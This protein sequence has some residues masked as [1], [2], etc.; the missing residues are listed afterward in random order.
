MQRLRDLIASLPNLEVLVLEA[1]PDHTPP[2]TDED[3]NRLVA[4]ISSRS[5]WDAHLKWQASIHG[6]PD[7]WSR[8]EA[9][10][11]GR[12]RQLAQKAIT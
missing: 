5:D 1:V 7:L 12:R 6:E 2:L 11:V 10:V 9:V 4:D 3:D 8:A